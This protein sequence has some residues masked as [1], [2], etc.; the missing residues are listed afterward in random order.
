[1]QRSFCFQK[2]RHSGRRARNAVRTTRPW[3]A[4][5]TSAL[6]NDGARAVGERHRPP[7]QA[8][9][10]R[11]RARPV[12]PRRSAK[13]CLAVPGGPVSDSG[14][15]RSPTDE[16]FRLQK[17]FSLEKPEPQRAPLAFERERLPAPLRRA[18]TARAVAVSASERPEAATLAQARS[19]RRPRPSPRQTASVLPYQPPGA[20]LASP[21][22]AGARTS[23]LHSRGAR[24]ADA[25]SLP[26]A[27]AL[28]R[29]PGCSHSR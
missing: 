20:P 4:A 19:P 3:R 27:S 23:R 14:D 22:L 15:R 26:C 8:S 24:P 10:T 6:L 1:M 11:R 16:Q 5:A 25:G 17:R 21:A 29:S 28:L 13:Q 12:P 18:D 2:P 9:A 7:A